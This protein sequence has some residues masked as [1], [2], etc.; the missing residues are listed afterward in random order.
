MESGLVIF[1][2]LLVTTII[3]IVIQILLYKD[4]KNQKSKYPLLWEEFD[5]IKESNNQKRK[6][7]VGNRLVYNKYVTTEHLEIILKTA[8]ESEVHHPE[9]KQLR[10]NAY[11]KWIYNTQARGHGLGSY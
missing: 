3:G 9:F 4:R 7:E 1:I 2:T 8:K 6:I 10:L 11:D 5:K